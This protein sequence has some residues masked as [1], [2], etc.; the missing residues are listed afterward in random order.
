MEGGKLSVVTKDSPEVNISKGKTLKFTV[1]AKINGNVMDPFTVSIKLNKAVPSVSVKAAGSINPIDRTTKVTYTATV[2]NL[3]TTNPGFELIELDSNGVDMDK[4]DYHF[5]LV[6]DEKNKNV[7]YVRVKDG[8][9]VESDKKYTLRFK[10]TNIPIAKESKIT[11]TPKQILPVV[12]QDVK[13]RTIYSLQDD[14]TFNVHVSHEK[15]KDTV[16]K[17]PEISAIVWAKDTPAAV[18]KAFDYHYEF[19]DSD[20]TSSDITVELVNPA[21]LVQEKTYTLNF[22]ILYVDQAPNSTGNTVSVKV[23]VK[24]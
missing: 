19:K 21:A 22:A 1:S 14:R 10:Y 8:M 12:K 24:K 15:K 11:V 5:E 6:T 2:K 16:V 20:L 7:A 17:E 13:S 18:K 3:V 9:S 4:K 23:T